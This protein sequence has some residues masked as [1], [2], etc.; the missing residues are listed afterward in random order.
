[1]LQAEDEVDFVI[2]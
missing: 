1:M 2:S